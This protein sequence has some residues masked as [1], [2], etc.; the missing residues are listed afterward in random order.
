MLELILQGI[1]SRPLSVLCVGAHSDD[2]ELGCGGVVL[3]LQLEF[4]GIHID[5]VVFGAEAQRA[6]E[7]RASAERFTQAAGSRCV[8]IF[9]FRDGFFPYIGAE[10]KECFEALKSRV[11]PDLIF[12]HHLHDR[13]QDHRFVAELTWNTFRNHLILEYEIVKYD[14]DLGHPNV[15]VPLSRDTCD[16]KVSA[17]VKHFQSQRE[18]HW[19][20]EET[21]MAA[22]RIRGVECNAEDGFAEAFYGRKLVCGMAKSGQVENK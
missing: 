9:G 10:I 14:G 1:R 4:P 18:K 6:Q 11:L 22:M 17:L 2:I 19:F 5:W 21:F 3:K 8:N 16:G 7:A 20:H 13:H 15:Y 12:T